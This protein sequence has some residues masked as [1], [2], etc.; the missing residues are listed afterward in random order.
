[1]PLGCVFIYSWF[2]HT[3]E[4]ITPSA[5]Q[6]ANKLATFIFLCTVNFR[7]YF[8]QK[9]LSIWRVTQPD[10]LKHGPS[11]CIQTGVTIL[12]QHAYL[13]TVCDRDT[14]RNKE[15]SRFRTH[16]GHVCPTYH[17]ISVHFKPLRSHYKVPYDQITRQISVHNKYRAWT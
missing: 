4:T 15:R 11:K 8:P 13:M 9:G 2:R 6:N 17:S 5:Y 12:V 7:S 10:G 14:Y 1:M 3:L 16:P